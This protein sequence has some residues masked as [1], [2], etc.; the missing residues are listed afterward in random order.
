MN[1]EHLFNDMLDKLKDVNQRPPYT[2]LHE[3]AC[4]TILRARKSL[5]ANTKFVEPCYIL[6]RWWSRAQYRANEL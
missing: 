5:H 1:E 4:R 6:L 3:R 2:C